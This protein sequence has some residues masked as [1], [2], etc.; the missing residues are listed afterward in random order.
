MV[1]ELVDVIGQIGHLFVVDIKFNKEEAVYVQHHSRICT[2]RYTAQ[3]LKKKKK[4]ILDATER[5]AH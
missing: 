1:L 2:T 5:S 3:F 4:K